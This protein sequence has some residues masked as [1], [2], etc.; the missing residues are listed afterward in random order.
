MSYGC[1]THGFAQLKNS[2]NV[3]KIPKSS[4]G[5]PKSLKNANLWPAS[6][7]NSG[8]GVSIGEKERII[9]IGVAFLKYKTVGIK[10]KKKK[11]I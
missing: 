11:S 8:A 5:K 1:P 2:T 6:V 9:K 3:P 10:Q 7:G 4:C